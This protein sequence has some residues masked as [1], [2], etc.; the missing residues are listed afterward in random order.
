MIYS[1][2]YRQDHQLKTPIFSFK[3]I[4]LYINIKYN[5]SNIFVDIH[6][7]Y[8][9]PSSIYH[10]QV[11]CA[12]NISNYGNCQFLKLSNTCILYYI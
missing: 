5:M 12:L 7:N 11:Q 2:I 9:Q 3:K 8:D 6:I 10:H 4:C 1:E